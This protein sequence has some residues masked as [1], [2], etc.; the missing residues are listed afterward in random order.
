MKTMLRTCIALAAMASF[1][2]CESSRGDDGDLATGEPPR[3]TVM[4]DSL[5]TCSKCRIAVVDS[6]RL[7][8][9]DDK[10]IPVRPPGFLRDSRG[11]NYLTFNGWGDQPILKYDS[12][13]R[14]VG[15]VGAKGRGPGEYE[16]TQ[17]VLLGP[18][19]S[20]FVFSSYGH[21][22]QVFT[23]SSK[24]ARVFSLDAIQPIEV[25]A[26]GTVF[27]Q[28]TRSWPPGDNALHV[29]VFNR[30][31]VLQD[32][33]PVFSPHNGG[34]A[35]MSSGKESFKV[36]MRVETL[37]HVAS[38]GALWTYAQGNYRL[39]QHDTNG[40]ARKLFGVRVAGEPA[41]L[42]TATEIDSAAKEK[43]YITSFN[44]VTSKNV[45]RKLN[46]RM[47]VDT[48]SAGLL[49]VSRQIPAPSWDTVTTK[50][51][52]PNHEAPSEELIPPDVE[53]RLYHT[54]VEVIDPRVGRLLARHEFPFRGV[55]VRGGYIGRVTANDDGY[56]MPSVYSLALVRQ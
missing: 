46:P 47:W 51:S 18:A 45:S 12:A 16:M 21:A 55:R 4:I 20:V 35:T 8:A 36:A 6:V 11:R 1:S 9:P 53:D 28:R 7:G 26:N 5:P 40:V 44:R 42:M 14:F 25:S 23:D 43:R 33:I 10:L 56:Y 30:E 31:G 32:S 24:Y 52:P 2:A 19:D 22:A 38:S 41:P 49:W 27:G 13:G 37:A 34:T 17:W 15:R 29:L 48:D 3:D 54:I 50:G 39:E